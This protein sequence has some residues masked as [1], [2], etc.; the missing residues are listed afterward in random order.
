MI[1]S[2]GKE[3]DIFL[4]IPESIVSHIED[5]ANILI[6][7]V[8]KVYERSNKHEFVCL[9]KNPDYYLSR[10]FPCL[11]PYGR[12]CPSDKFCRSISIAKYT[13]HM[14]CLGGG[15]EP[16]RFQQSS[17]FIFTLYNM[18]M[19]RKIGGVAYIAQK[20]NLDGSD[21]DSEVA[22]SIGEINSL[23]EYLRI[24]PSISGSG[25]SAQIHDEREMQQ[26]IKRLIPYSQS[27]QGTPTHIAYER[28]KLM[29]MIPSPI[30]N[31]IGAWRLFLTLSPADKYEN[32]LFELVLSTV[33][34]DSQDAW[35]SR[36]EKVFPYFLFSFFPFFLFSFFSFFF[37]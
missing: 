7:P 16:R 23:L 8:S 32:R 13:K 12:G 35:Q 31:K 29:A 19:K 26:L 14:L 6:D 2:A 20:K 11:Y 22:P 28:V 1:G 30:I 21:V 34:D 24:P 10:C 27:L 9:F 25:T 18:E 5:L 3:T 4:E 15:P 37:L 17:K 36:T 33:T